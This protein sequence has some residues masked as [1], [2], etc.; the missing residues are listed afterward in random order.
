[1][2]I[3]S[4]LW[5]DTEA[6]ATVA[7]GIPKPSRELDTKEMGKF[8]F[9]CDAVIQDS[10]WKHGKDIPKIVEGIVEW[11][12]RLGPKAVMAWRERQDAEIEVRN[13]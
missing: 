7:K 8:V 3:P 2:N 13:A 9:M 5:Q 4:F 1:M 12:A 10:E 6:D 11:E